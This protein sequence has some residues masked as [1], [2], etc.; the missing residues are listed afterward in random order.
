MGVQPIWTLNPFPDADECAGGS[1]L[2]Q[3]FPWLEA[4]MKA[5][6]PSPTGLAVAVY[7]A[8]MR[9]SCPPHRAPV[10]QF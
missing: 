3:N 6:M 5:P 1:Q 2:D 4:E 8:F 7:S 9:G 10:L